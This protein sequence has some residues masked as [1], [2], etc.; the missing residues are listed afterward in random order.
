MRRQARRLQACLGDAG[1]AAGTLLSERLASSGLAS[2]SGTAAGAAFATAAQGL[3][4]GDARALRAAARAYATLVRQQGGQAG[5]VVAGAGTGAAALRR[6]LQAR[7]LLLA[8][9]VRP[10]EAWNSAQGAVLCSPRRRPA[11][12]IC[13][14]ASDSVHAGAQAEYGLLARRGFCT[15]PPPKGASLLP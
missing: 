7:A 15:E 8:C 6:T 1:S 13:A 11:S 5:A 2:A 4:R 14:A 12:R 10:R 9:C 3:Q